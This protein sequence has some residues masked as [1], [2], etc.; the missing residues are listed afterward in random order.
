[1]KKPTNEEFRK[2]PSTP[3]NKYHLLQ[4]LKY[5]TEKV[6]LC[7]GELQG[8]T[9]VRIIKVGTHKPLYIQ[10]QNHFN[11]SLSVV[12][13]NHFYLVLQTNWNTL[14]VRLFSFPESFSLLTLKLTGELSGFKASSQKMHSFCSFYLI[15][16]KISVT[17]E[18]FFVHKVQLKCII[19]RKNTCL[20]FTSLSNSSGLATNVLLYEVST[21]DVKPDVSHFLSPGS[22]YPFSMKTVTVCES[23]LLTCLFPAKR[24]ALNTHTQQQRKFISQLSP[25]CHTCH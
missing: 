16:K 12:N 2:D 24:K 3:A 10:T 17:T 21:R 19:E 22:V 4:A 6:Y 1:M 7:E 18:N 15:G 8:W 5:K 11:D 13:I 9:D 20:L 25:T 23:V 14:Y